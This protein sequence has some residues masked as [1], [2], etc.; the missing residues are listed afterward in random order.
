MNAISTDQPK[1]Q[2]LEAAV[3]TICSEYGSKEVLKAA[4]RILANQPGGCQAGHIIIPG[5]LSISW[6]VH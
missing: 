1:Q 6:R 4:V 2:L 5:D 3:H